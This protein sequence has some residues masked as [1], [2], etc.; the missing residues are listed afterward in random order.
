[1]TVCGV[2]LAAGAGR[3]FG[4]AKQLADLDGR[5]LLQRAVDVACAAPDLDRVLVVLGA[6]ADEVRAG[7]AFG[8]AEV[9]VC[10]DW[11]EGVA[12]SLRCGVA[13]A[14]GA[15]WVVITLGDEPELPGAALPAIVAA[16]CRA[17]AQVGAVRALW[18][19][20][21]G[22]PV[23]LRASL[24]AR[25]RELR[26]DVGARAL[27]NDT[28]VLEVDCGDLGTPVD[29]DTPADLEAIRR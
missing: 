6:G 12:A 21:P 27:L 4:A 24:A 2:V 19:G 15:E 28:V 22:H 20:R 10:D 23:A 3:R 11:S 17:P 13:A 7:V 16:A 18:T 8:R 5:P 1:V 14:A 29:V 26:G 9:V 25:V